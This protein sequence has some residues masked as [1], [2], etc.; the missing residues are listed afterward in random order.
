M[1]EF[2]CGKHTFGDIW[3]MNGL[4][5]SIQEAADSIIILQLALF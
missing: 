3:R 5:S 1:N 2:E 4:I